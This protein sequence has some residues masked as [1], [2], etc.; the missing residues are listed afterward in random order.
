MVLGEHLANI[1]LFVH[2]S[3]ILFF[4]LLNLLMNSEIAV[5]ILQCFAQSFSV[6]SAAKLS[7]STTGNKR[8]EVEVRRWEIL[9]S[10]W[11]ED[12]Q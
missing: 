2:I 11:S 5:V 10:H 7:L 1:I 3:V 4:Y 6:E 9:V 12:R 8:A